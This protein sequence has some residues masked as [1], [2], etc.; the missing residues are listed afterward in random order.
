MASGVAVEDCC[1]LTF[2]DLKLGHKY[3]YVIFR[4]S[5]D[6]KA[7]T[8]DK[9]ADPSATYDDL[10]NDLKEAEKNA[11]CRWAVMDVD[12]KSVNGADKSKLCFIHWN[13][14]N[15][16]MK[17]KMV[18]ASSKLAFKSALGEKFG[19]EL[20]AT[21]YSELS[22]NSLMDIVKKNDKWTAL[23]FFASADFVVGTVMNCS[24]FAAFSILYSS[25]DK[26]CVSTVTFATSCDSTL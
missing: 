26:T 7:I 12:Y 8:V 6:Y 21:D 17:Q 3:R 10:V 15:A 1:K 2:Q 9:T 24:A 19:T 5:A 11:E 18:F 13:P 4:L 25:L 20:Q 14:D 22:Y 16:K 23:L